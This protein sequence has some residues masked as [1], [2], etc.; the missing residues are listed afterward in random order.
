VLKV[1]LTIQVLATNYP[2][3]K[4]SAMHLHKLGNNQNPTTVVLFEENW[5]SGNFTANNRIFEP[6]VGN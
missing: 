5:S 2:D 6:S 3:A 1:L 4:L